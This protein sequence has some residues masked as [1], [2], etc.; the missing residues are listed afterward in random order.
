MEKFI[1]KNF[2]KV[3]YKIAD[4]IIENN[5][6]HSITIK[7]YKPDDNMPLIIA[8]DNLIYYFF[9]LNENKEIIQIIKN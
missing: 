7:Y 3:K 2:E 9:K 6:T 1:G 5:C 4:Y 8:E